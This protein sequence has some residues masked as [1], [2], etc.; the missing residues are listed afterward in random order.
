MWRCAIGLVVFSVSK[1]IDTSFFGV[2]RPEKNI[3][4][5]F[6]LMIKLILKCIVFWFWGVQVRL[7]SAIL[8]NN[9]IVSY[10]ATGKY[11]VCAI[12]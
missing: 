6:G 11:V 3:C 2:E 5:K 4:M 8:S 12:C 1:N 7:V 9:L 10:H